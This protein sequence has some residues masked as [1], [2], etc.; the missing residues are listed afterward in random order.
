MIMEASPYARKV[1]YKFLVKEGIRD[2]NAFL[3]EEKK[4]VNL[5]QSKTGYFKRKRGKTY[6]KI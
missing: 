3:L 4:K 6:D 1:G 5:S 2:G